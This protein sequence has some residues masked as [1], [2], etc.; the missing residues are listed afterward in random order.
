M[1]IVKCDYCGKEF[2]RDAYH[3]KLYKKHYCCDECRLKSFNQPVKVKCAYCGKTI[4]LRKSRIDNKRCK[5]HFCNKEC[6]LK[7]KAKE[8]EQNKE[9]TIERIRSYHRAYYHLHPELKEARKIYTKT[10]KFRL[11]AI[12]K[13]E[14]YKKK[15]YRKS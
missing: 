13:I 2:K 3:L 15:K 5:R 8:K 7:Q 14:Q 11:K 6:F 10:S 12:E 1:P 4:T 9:K